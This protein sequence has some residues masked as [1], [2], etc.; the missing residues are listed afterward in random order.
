MQPRTSG[1]PSRGW[2]RQTALRFLSEKGAP[3]L[4]APALSALSAACQLCIHKRDG[5]LDGGVYSQITGI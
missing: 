3:N 2:G 1:A 5:P 4:E